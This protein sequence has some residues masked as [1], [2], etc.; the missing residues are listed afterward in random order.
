M[1]TS[2][3]SSCKCHQEVSPFTLSPSHWWLYSSIVPASCSWR[4][5]TGSQVH[6][7]LSWSYKAVQQSA[8]PEVA[9]EPTLQACAGLGLSRQVEG[10]QWTL[11]HLELSLEVMQGLAQESR[12]K[13]GL[14]AS[15]LPRVPFVVYRGTPQHHIPTRA[16]F[17][18]GKGCPLRCSP[19]AHT[20]C[21]DCQLLLPK[22]PLPE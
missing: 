20:K 22:R 17:C 3:N 9:V 8:G 10:R 11:Q 13:P 7:A 5:S 4:R 2:S 12:R 1:S 14:K 21:G 16:L 6:T 15:D 18:N 19:A